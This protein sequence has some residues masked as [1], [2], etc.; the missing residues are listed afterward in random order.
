MHKSCGLLKLAQFKKANLCHCYSQHRLKF[1][2]STMQY[3]AA[4]CLQSTPGLSIT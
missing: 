4:H 1:D 2:H 3:E